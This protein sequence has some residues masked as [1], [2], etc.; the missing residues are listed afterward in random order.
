MTL[1][2]ETL[3]ILLFKIYMRMAG[4]K[5]DKWLGMHTAQGFL[6]DEESTSARIRDT[7]NSACPYK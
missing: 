1:H 7:I 4:I 5:D 6:P 3:Y 2:G